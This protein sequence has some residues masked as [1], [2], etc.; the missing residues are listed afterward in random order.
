MSSFHKFFET[1]CISLGSQL[2]KNGHDRII[3]Y[4]CEMRWCTRDK[5]TNWINTIPSVSIILRFYIMQSLPPTLNSSLQCNIS[6]FLN[7]LYEGLWKYRHVQQMINGSLTAIWHSLAFANSARRK[8]RLVFLQRFGINIMRSIFFPSTQ[9][10]LQLHRACCTVVIFHIPAFS[11]FGPLIF[12]KR[13][14][15]KCE[16]AGNKTVRYVKQENLENLID[17]SI[18]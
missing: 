18:P 16:R 17:V 8:G 15:G 1:V 13:H 10:T 6:Q 11:H 3:V 7:Q 12:W 5:E 9:W 4:G 14:V 2:H